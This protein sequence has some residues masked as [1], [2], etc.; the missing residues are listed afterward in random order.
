MPDHRRQAARR[1]YLLPA[2]VA[3]LALA[4]SA[5]ATL[6]AAL[7][8]RG[9]LAAEFGWSGVLQALVAATSL[10]V[11]AAALPWALPLARGRGVR[12]TVT[13]G[14]L[15]AGLIALLVLPN[16]THFWQMLLGGLA[17]GATRAGILAGVWLALRRLFGARLSLALV[18]LLSAAGALLVTP[19][20]SQ[21]VYRNSWREGAAACAGLLLA[22]CAPLAYVLLPGRE[23]AC[24]SEDRGQRAQ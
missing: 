10:G 21:V 19:W 2:A 7:P 9:P 14:S 24:T 15:G 8:L 11:T 12:L 22:V 18:A 5:G 1:P 4:L 3:G 23:A 13:G 16:L 6:W 20:V 17:L